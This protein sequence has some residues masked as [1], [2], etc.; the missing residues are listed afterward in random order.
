[1]FC[2]GAGRLNVAILGNLMNPL[3]PELGIA[4]GLV[5]ATVVM[6]LI[7]LDVLLT[8]TGVHARKFMIWLHVDRLLVPLGVVFGLFVLHGLEIWV[9]A[10]AYRYVG[11]LGSLEE[12][13][14]YSASAYTTL[15]EGGGLLPKT[16]RVVGALE[17][18]NGS[19]LI[20]WSIGLMFS[21]LSRLLDSANE[22]DHR[23]PRG[24]IARS[25]LRRRAA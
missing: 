8:L 25:A 22:E 12:A 11:P 4:T 16:W 6:H 2:F 21:V 13:I 3:L 5:V 17:A 14:Y 24:V 18:I 10:L 15:G 1:V 9:Y 19:L 7:G 20:G 23:V